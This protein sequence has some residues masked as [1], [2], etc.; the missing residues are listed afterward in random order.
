MSGDNSST[1]QSYIDSAT[2]AVQSAI[3]SLTGN[4]ADQTKGDARQDKA[5]AEQDLSHS[6]GKLGPYAVSGSGGISK[7]DPNRQEGAWNQTVGSAKETVGNVFGAEG[8]K[9]EGREQNLSG[10]GQEAQGQLN[11]FGGGMA[12][13]VA[14]ATG[15]AFAG[16]TGDKTAQEHYQDQHDTGKTAQRS[17][18]ADIQRQNQ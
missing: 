2:G 9:K 11:D 13:R 17:A 12:D 6:V 5:S 14:G 15:S 10:Q 1:L 4:T 8:L 3:G 7:D 16:L 18:E